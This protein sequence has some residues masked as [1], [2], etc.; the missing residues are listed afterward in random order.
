MRDDI[1][2]VLVKTSRY[3]SR[4]SGCVL[5][6]PPNPAGVKAGGD[7]E[8]RRPSR[9]PTVA[10]QLSRNLD[11]RLM[12]P[13]RSARSLPATLRYCRRRLRVSTETTL[14]SSGESRSP[15][16]LGTSTGRDELFGMAWRSTKLAKGF[17][18]N[19]R[20]FRSFHKPVYHFW[21]YHQ[22]INDRDLRMWARRPEIKIGNHKWN[23]DVDLYRTG[24]RRSRRR[25]STRELVDISPAALRRTVITVVG[26][27]ARDRR[28]LRRS[29][30]VCQ[31]ASLS[32]STRRTPTGNRFTARDLI[33]I[34]MPNGVSNGGE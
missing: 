13:E 24:R 2:F 23:A 12:L 5:F 21:L 10:F 8:K 27:F 34:P 11:A 16:V 25:R 15:F 14:R 9:I 17:K 32:Q 31:D 20:A 4:S 1:D 26:S 28:R 29:D 19:Q 6:N 33:S 3:A 30:H 7:T 18:A 22:L